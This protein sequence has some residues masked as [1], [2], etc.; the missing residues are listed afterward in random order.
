MTCAKPLAA[1][2]VIEPV[3]PVVRSWTITV[4][5]AAPSWMSIDQLVARVHEQVG[6]RVRRERAVGAAQRRSRTRAGRRDFVMKAKFAGSS[7]ARAAAVVVV[8]AGVVLVL[9]QAEDRHRGAPLL[10]V[11]ADSRRPGRPARRIELQL[12]ERRARVVADVVGGVRVGAVEDVGVAVGRARRVR[13]LRRRLVVAQCH[14][15]PESRMQLEVERPGGAAL[16]RQHLRVGRQ[17][18]LVEVRVSRARAVRVEQQRRL[19]VPRVLAGVADRV[20]RLRT[21]HRFGL[22]AVRARPPAPN[23]QRREHTTT[24]SAPTSLT[25]SRFTVPPLTPGLGPPVPQVEGGLLDL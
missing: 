4:R 13:E 11:A 9:E 5:P 22:T 7:P 21:E 24:A 17:L 3:L 1:L 6:R 15:E 2:A 23:R 10:R 14:P 19:V 8:Q 20:V 18:Q 25:S 16:I 12:E